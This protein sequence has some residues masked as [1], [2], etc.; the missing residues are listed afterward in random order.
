MTAGDT[1]RDP[2]PAEPRP[3]TAIERI[4]ARRETETVERHA[5]VRR[6][7]APLAWPGE[8]GGG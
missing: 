4:H 2:V 7:K 1:E 6:R 3:M 5:R 8:V